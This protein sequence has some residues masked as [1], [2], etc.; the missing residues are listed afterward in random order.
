M[1]YQGLAY[2]TSNRGGCHLRANML[3]PTVLGL[4]KLVDRFNGAGQ[5]GLLIELQ[6]VNAVLDSLVSC[7][8]GHMALGEEHYSRLLS[9]VTGR[10]YEE[11]EM[12]RVGERVWTLER[13]CNIRRG[14]GTKD[15]TLPPRLLHEPAPDGPARG[16]VVDLAPMLEEYYRFRGWS[17]DGVPSGRKLAE[18]GLEGE[19]RQVS[20]C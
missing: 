3:G 6:N 9:S 15:D 13:L 18:L 7:K 8:F 14:F 2:A 12:L 1:A 10:K 19:G 4:P 17:H 20:A 5:A 16:R 11:A